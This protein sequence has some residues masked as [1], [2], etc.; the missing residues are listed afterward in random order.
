[1]EIGV[2]IISVFAAI[3]ALFAHYGIRQDRESFDERLEL[4]NNSPYYKVVPVP[5]KKYGIKEIRYYP[6]MSNFPMI[7][8]EVLLHETYETIE[9]AEEEIKH[10]KSISG[11]LNYYKYKNIT[12]E[13][14]Y[15][16]LVT[17]K[18]KTEGL[19]NVT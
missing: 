7:P 11:W 16:W 18:T 19:L 8:S 17:Y 12:K 13:I 5:G 2:I 15:D 3:L 14:Y 9:S 10:L 6:C 1:M 4:I